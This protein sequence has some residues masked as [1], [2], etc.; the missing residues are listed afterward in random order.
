M[1]CLFYIPNPQKTP[2]SSLEN[3]LN[4]RTHLLCSLHVSIQKGN[5][6]RNCCASIVRND[7]G[8]LSSPPRFFRSLG[9]KTHVEAIRLPHWESST[10]RNPLPHGFA[11]L[12]AVFSPHEKCRHW[13]DVKATT[14]SRNTKIRLACECELLIL[15]FGSHVPVTLFCICPPGVFLNV[16]TCGDIPTITAV[17]PLYLLRRYNKLS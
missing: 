16:S 6:Q 7:S 10:L 5:S 12:L 13:D 11:P 17:T 4:N 15:I 14:C 8:S 3:C 1:F 2:K 9:G